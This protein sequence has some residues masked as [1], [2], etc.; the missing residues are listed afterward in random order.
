ME[1]LP[2]GPAPAP[3]NQMIVGTTIAVIAMAMLTG[4]MLAMWALERREAIN[5]DGRWLPSSVTIPEV[6]SNIMLIA[7]AGI[8][9]FAQ[10]AVWSTT[11]GDKPHTVF[12]LGSTA[13]VAVLVLNAQFYI[14]SQIDLGVAEGRYGSMFFAITGMFVA[15][16]IAGVV[17]SLVAMFRFLAGR[18]DERELLVAHAV[19]WYA[20][21]AVYAAIW[22][23]VYV[24]K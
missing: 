2:A 1:A 7:F 4:G 8:C 5:A 9:S 19:F 17:F 21:S 6:P 24:T 22:F 15:I 11:R 14:Y 20:M 3:R 13:F 10:W 16:M 18:T 12:A 23:V